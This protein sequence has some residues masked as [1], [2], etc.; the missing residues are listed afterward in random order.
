MRIYGV[1]RI[2]FMGFDVQWI[3]VSVWQFKLLQPP[4][5]SVIEHVRILFSK[6]EI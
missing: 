5:G 6:L 1:C 3:A 4:T 2:G